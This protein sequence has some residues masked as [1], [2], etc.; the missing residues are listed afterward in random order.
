MNLLGDVGAIVMNYRTLSGGIALMLALTMTPSAASAAGSGSEPSP[1]R[2]AYAGTNTVDPTGVSTHSPAHAVTSGIAPNAASTVGGRHMAVLAPTAAAAVGNA[3]AAGP[4]PTL[5]VNRANS[6]CSDTAAGAGSQ[7][8][9]FCTLQ[10][11]ADN[12]TAGDTVLVTAGAY[13]PFTISA[14]G[15][16]SAPITFKPASGSRS[17]IDIFSSSLKA[18]TPVHAIDVEGSSHLDLEGFWINVTAT[19]DFV[20][21]NNSHD[22]TFDR[23][24]NWVAAPSSIKPGA[25]IHVTGNSTAITLTRNSFANGLNEPYIQVDAGGSGDVIADNSMWSDDVTP[26]TVAGTPGVEISGNSIATAAGVAIALTGASPNSTIE[27]NIVATRLYYTNV[28]LVAGIE[29]DAGSTSGTTLDYNLTYDVGGSTPGYS[30]NGVLYPTFG[31]LLAATGQGAHE[32]SGNPQLYLGGDEIVPYWDSP[33]INSAN[34]AAPGEQP[35]DILS[36]SCVDDPSY[37]VTGAGNPAYCTRGEFQYQDP[38]TAMVT[39][40]ENASMSATA[41]ATLSHGLH[42]VSSY[43]F[44]FGDGT[45][46]VVNTNG[47]TH[48]TYARSGAFTVAVTVTDSTGATNTAAAGVITIGADFTPVAP[49]RVL[50]TRNG[51]GTGYAS[52]ITPGNAVILPLPAAVAAHGNWL[53]GVALNLTVTDATGNGFV[54]TS[55]WN[56]SSVNYTAGQTV[57]GMTIAPVY[58]N[59]GLLSV[60]L[61]NTGSGSI[62]LIADLTGFFAKDSTSGYHPLSPARLMDT[63]TGLGGFQGKLTPGQPD[64]LT[65]AGSAAGAVPSTGVTAVAV[66]LTVTDTTGN[67]FLTAYPDGTPLPNTSNVNFAKGQTVA[68]FAILP[69]GADGKLDLADSTSSDVIVDIVGYFDSTGGSAFVTSDAYR[70]IDT[71]NGDAAWGCNP[72]KGAL[73]PHAALAANLVCQDAGYPV[74]TLG[75][76]TAV[77]VNNTVT[78]TAANGFLAVYPTGAPLPNSSNVNWLAGSTVA[79]FAIAATGTNGEISFYNE[80]S[81]STQ[82]IVDVYGFFADS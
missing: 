66:N 29:V 27:D 51:T 63:R 64:A 46:P 48:H 39:A 4:G 67:G 76:V 62:D 52:K 82:L 26:L 50:D 10:A 38:L 20:L 73:Q 79:N 49:T 19:G 53:T 54:G 32:L 11:A 59:G 14:Q 15:T 42:G 80:S 71:R 2:S 13:Q 18:T 68:N 72:A 75:H 60:W 17:S 21:I 3:T 33:A 43:S 56:T 37:P 23:S 45:T 8:V 28:T 9:P 31:A 30:W 22:V 24:V 40:T 69:V 81:G 77:A 36:Q 6:N 78:L 25:S 44:D 74:S 57:A 35:T 7:A 61:A 16:A 12:V 41:D 5:Y 65:V 70:D 47:T 34:S 58:N 55:S 1:H